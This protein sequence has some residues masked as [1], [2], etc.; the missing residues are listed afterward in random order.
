M[1]PHPLLFC[2]S[3]V[4]KNQK[5]IIDKLET[6]KQPE[7]LPKLANIVVGWFVYKA[8]VA[9]IFLHIS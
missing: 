7:L 4:K 9:I 8:G 6:M 3:F 5:G 2:V 1:D